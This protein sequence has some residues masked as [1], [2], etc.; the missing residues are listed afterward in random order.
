MSSPAGRREAMEQLTRRGG[1]QR[2][3]C[4]Y[5]GCSRR[6]AHY[7]LRQ[8]EKDRALGERL[9]G[10]AQQYPRFGYRRSAVWVDQ[11]CSGCGD[12]GGGLG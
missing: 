10:T 5:L 6:V 9:M 1:S 7:R 4:R 2:A 12:C 11:A 8:P 3:A